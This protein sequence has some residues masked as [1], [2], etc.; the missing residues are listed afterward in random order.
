MYLKFVS[1]KF[2]SF[3]SYIA[4]YKIELAL[5]IRTFEMLFAYLQGEGNY[6]VY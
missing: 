3:L 4:A 2:G 5:F 6:N 1:T